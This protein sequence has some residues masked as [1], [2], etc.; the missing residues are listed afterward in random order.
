[1]I[2]CNPCVII[3][4]TIKIKLLVSYKRSKGG[5][6]AY[7]NTG[8]S[9]LNVDCI[10]INFFFTIVRLFPSNFLCFYESTIMACI[11]QTFTFC[12]RLLLR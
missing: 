9:H 2:M 4:F 3:E 7:K 1:M 11:G 5:R 10:L 6:C 8:S 12:Q